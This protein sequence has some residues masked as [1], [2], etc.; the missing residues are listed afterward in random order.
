MNFNV[1]VSSNINVFE[2][3]ISKT[4]METKGEYKKLWRMN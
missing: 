4:R 1:I 3:R 2:K